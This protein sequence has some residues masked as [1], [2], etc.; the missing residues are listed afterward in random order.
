MDFNIK[1]VDG[2]SLLYKFI[3][4]QNA[5][6]VWLILKRG[7]DTNHFN[8]MHNTCLH[9][10]IMTGNIEIIN[11]LFFYGAQLTLFNDFD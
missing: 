11:L 2:N 1:D 6:A 3:G 8:E 5:P 9:I 4:N 7:A 10:A